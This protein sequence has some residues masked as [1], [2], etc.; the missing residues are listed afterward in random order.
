[1]GKRKPIYEELET[2]LAKTKKQSLLANQRLKYLLCA[3]PAVFYTSK[4]SDEFGATFVSESITQLTGYEPHQF[5]NESS[6]WTNHIHPEDIKRILS[7]F[8]C[9]F[10]QERYAYEYRF[11]CKDNSYIWIRDEMKLVHDKDGQ[12]FEIIGNWID[13]T[14]HKQ[15][16]EELKSAHE[17]AKNLIDSSLDMIIS[18]DKERK[19]VEFNKAAQAIFG[20]RKA[21]VPGKHVDILYADPAEGLKTHTIT[22]RTGRF[23]AEIMNKRKNGE[24][25]PTFLSASI[26][27]DK[28]GE[29]S[30]VMG[31]LRDITGLKRSEKEKENLQDQLLQSQ[32]M[33][34]IGESASGIAHD[35]NNLLTIISGYSQLLLGR[36]DKDIPIRQGIE[37]IY[38][39]GEQATSLIR[40]L[41]I[42]GRKQ[43]LKPKALD[44]NAVVSDVEK[45]LRR[46]IGENI[47]L[48]V[49]LGT[50][51]YQVK[52]DRGQ[53]EQTIMNLVVNARDALPE[54]GRIT[55]QTQN[56]ALNKVVC[57]TIPESVPGK[58]VQII[59][60]D[61]GVGIDKEILNHIFEP[62]FTTKKSGEGTG[63]G[64]SVV[65]GIIK[66]HKGWINVY[67][68][69]GRGSAFKFYLPAILTESGEEIKKAVSIETLRGKGERI[70]LVEDEEDVRQFASTVLREYG[71]IIFEAANGKEAEFFFENEGGNFDLVFSDVV[72]P[73]KTGLQ[74]IDYILSRKPDL[75]VLLSSGYSDRE[76]QWSEIKKRKLR[77]LQKPYVVTDLLKS[78]KEVI[79]SEGN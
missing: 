14:E 2:R 8:P 59:V 37:K 39:A 28:S 26:L 3:T 27:R 23:S 54:G 64:L 40:Q 18:V 5:V 30:G 78:I 15:M 17:Y 75:R 48:E 20:Y 33:E 13:I 65:Y 41:L 49:I 69:P 70:L 73:D 1:M 56:V 36:I 47:K 32:K 60:E 79:H 16:V 58:F 77:F 63:L 61:T 71:Y 44:L 10:E 46:L 62:F 29:F 74:L 19:I 51:L 45:M 35:F 11:Q 72:L 52:A 12:P 7:E 34:A 42:F 66:Q 22:R 55:I 21:E 76:S 24:L 6:F 68:E 57:K 4:A 25:F 53:I 9:V 50:G 43:T 31:V 67:S 38:K